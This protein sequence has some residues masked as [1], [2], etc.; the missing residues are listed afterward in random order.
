MATTESLRIIY[1]QQHTKCRSSSDTNWQRSQFGLNNDP[2][3]PFRNG[4]DWLPDQVLTDVG[5]MPVQ[6]GMY[7]E[8]GEAGRKSQQVR[9]PC[10]SPAVR[11][12]AN[13]AFNCNKVVRNLGVIY[14]DIIIWKA[15][16]ITYARLHKYTKEI[17]FKNQALYIKKK[18]IF[19]K[20]QALY[21]E[22]CRRVLSTCLHSF[23]T[24]LC[25]GRIIWPSEIFHR[26]PATCAIFFSTAGH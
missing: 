24:R 16:W 5:A 3:C 4:I 1:L 22:R 21:H 14:D 20:N 10:C 11:G 6:E 17:F 15:M 2:V 9:G 25:K 18:E 13:D 12:L 19:F 7:R 26:K 8:N 23:K